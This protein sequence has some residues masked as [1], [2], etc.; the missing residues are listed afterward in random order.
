MQDFLDF[1]LCFTN[2]SSALLK[3][4]KWTLDLFT[5]RSDLKGPPSFAWLELEMRKNSAYEVTAWKKA[6]KQ[7]GVDPFIFG[8]KKLKSTATLSVN[9]AM[10][11][12]YEVQV[13]SVEIE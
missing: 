5:D 11:L 3:N 2:A 8:Y 1:G 10:N 7:E 4:Q 13:K 12:E 9:K 6:S